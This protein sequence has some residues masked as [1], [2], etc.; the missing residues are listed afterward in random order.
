MVD[1]PLTN[2]AC[3]QITTAQWAQME[4]DN[5]TPWLY[6]AAL[7]ARR[8]DGRAVD[9]ALLHASKAKSLRL[10]DEAP[11]RF[12]D[13][14]VLRPDNPVTTMMAI[15]Q[16][17]GIRAALPAPDLLAVGQ[18]CGLNGPMDDSRR[19]LCNDLAALLAERSSTLISTQIG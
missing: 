19:A 1:S 12:T 2:G 13:R 15:Y 16:L 18:Y 6:E 11:L 17:V 7:A 5:A 3:V 4:P 8:K 9:E 14:D 10:H